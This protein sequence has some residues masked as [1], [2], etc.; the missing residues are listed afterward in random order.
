MSPLPSR[1]VA[2][3]ALLTRIL[4]E[5][6]L[7]AAVQALP[8]P[9]LGKLIDHVGLEDAG[10]IVALATTLQLKRIFDDDLW[11]SERPGKDETFDAN[12]F[13]LWLEVMLEAGEAFAAEKLAELPEDLVTLA[14]HKHV[15]V[16]NIEELALAMADRMSDDDELTEKALESCLCEELDEYR[17]ISRNHEGWDAILTVLLALDRDHHDFLGRVLQHCCHMAADFIE[18]N[19]GL[20]QVLTSDEMLESDVGAEREERRAEEGFIAPSSAA[21]FLA[22]ARTTDLAD[23]L[24]TEERD[25]V[26]HAYFRSLRAPSHPSAAH[27]GAQMRVGTDAAKAASLVEILRDA[28]VLPASGPSLLLQGAPHADEASAQESGV[29]TQAMRRL[30]AHAVDLHGRRMQELAYLANVLAAGSSIEGRTLRP[31]EAAHLAVATCNLGMEHLLQDEPGQNPTASLLQR[32]SADKLFRIG[33]RLLGQDVV[34]AAARAFE[35]ALI[36]E[37][38]TTSNRE[39]AKALEQGTRALRAAIAAGKPWT[40][41]RKLAELEGE[42]DATTLTTLVALLDECPSLRGRLAPVSE[43]A[44]TKQEARFIATCEQLRSVQTFLAKL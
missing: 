24:A 18:E 44:P 8:A 31:F 10:E 11:R 29:F 39:R 6:N 1:K 3:R 38:R 43:D 35:N 32:K 15:L 23:I 42:V 9:A 21:S 26:T 40:S 2:P 7:V 28:D 17:I 25:P 37:A 4:D 5:P 22:L 33:W 12:R 41:L 19:G 36:R 30:G 27:D 20:Y 16:I 34:L 13:A 14:L